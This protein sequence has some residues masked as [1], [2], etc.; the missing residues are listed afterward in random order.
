MSSATE[1]TEVFGAPLIAS[2]LI[3]SDGDGSPVLQGGH[4]NNCD[5]YCFPYAAS[6][7]DC[8][9]PMTRVR[10][11]SEG[12][13]YSHTTVRT[14]PPYGFPRPYSVA[15]IDLNDAPLRIF[16]LLDCALAGQFKIGDRVRLKVGV[17]GHDGEG[18][19]RARPYFTLKER[20]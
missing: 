18:A 12:V 2:G 9:T 17:V 10:L 4:C 20:R 6:C 8:L 7:P 15:F 14:R 13:I 19:E 5:R 11:G 16:A 1:L 3:E